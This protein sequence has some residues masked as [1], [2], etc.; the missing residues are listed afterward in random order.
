MEKDMNK[1]I[2]K[3]AGFDK[4]VEKVEQGLCPTCSN[5]IDKSEFRNSI[6]LQE[7]EISGM[8]QNC[9]DSIFGKD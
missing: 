7:F 2:M 4:E 5:P 1:E 3:Q 9:Q 8:C 6:S